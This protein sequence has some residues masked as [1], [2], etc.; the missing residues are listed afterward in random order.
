MDY[1]DSDKVAIGHHLIVTSDDDED[2]DKGDILISRQ[3]GS[4][5]PYVTRVSD[6]L[7]SCIDLEHVEFHKESFNTHYEIY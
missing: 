6:G 1:E 4:T 3:S 5:H 2:Y 7:R